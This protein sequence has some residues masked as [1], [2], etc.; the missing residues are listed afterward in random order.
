MF[1]PSAST[2]TPDYALFP[3]K[4][5]AAKAHK[6]KGE[7]DYSQCIGIADAKYWE[8]D[9]DIYKN[10]KKDTFTHKNP[11]FQIISYL[12]GTQKNWGILTNGRLWRL[13]TL[14]SHMPIG[15]YY[16]VD[17]VDLLEASPDKLKYFYLF[18]RKEALISDANG[19]TFLDRVFEGSSDYAVELEN[20]IKDR[21]YEV[22][23][24]ICQGFAAN[25]TNK[26][27]DASELKEIYDNSLT[28]LYRLLFVF[29]AEAREL[30]PLTANQGY[31]DNYSLRSLIHKIE[32]AEKKKLPFSLKSTNYYQNLTNLFNLID[33][34]DP[35]LDVPEYNGGLFD[36]SEHPFLSQHAHC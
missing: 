15:N 31:R 3:D 11:S 25:F 1:K 34:G 27:L 29:Y 13:Y 33:S 14:K 19:K 5:T 22:V 26:Q 21:A 35:N 2:G 30:L 4:I 8:R 32:D 28:F 23:Q 7:T 16:Q 17:I 24:L 20:N 18:F 6:K 10:S 12:T 9:L 36:S